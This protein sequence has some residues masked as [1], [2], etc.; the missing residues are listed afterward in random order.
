[1]Q[2]LKTK[3]LSWH[4]MDKPG[5]TDIDWLK[6]NYNFHEVV[7]AELTRPTV[8]PKV[9]SYDHYLYMVLHFPIFDEKGRKTH[10]R[11]IDFLITKKELFTVTYDPVLPLESFFKTC[12]AEKTC[13][14]L[15][16][17]KTTGHLLFYILKELFEFSLRQLDHIQENINVIEEKIFSGF[18]RDVVEELSIIRRD[19]I[20]FRRAVKPEHITLDSLKEHGLKLFGKG[21]E[22]YFTGLIGEYMKVWNLL[23][24]NKETLDALYDNNTTLLEVKQNEIMKLFTILA[25][26]TFPLSLLVGI[27]GINTPHNPILGKVNDFWVIVGIVAASIITMLIVFKKKNWI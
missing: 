17:S 15:Y 13:E 11:E 5:K 14:E 22:P 10:Q 3:T 16:A 9:E 21:L 6:K 8:R 12:L 25:F 26:V 27:L 1:M 18:E 2:T 24:N 19:I 20:D 7:L 23:E 4:H